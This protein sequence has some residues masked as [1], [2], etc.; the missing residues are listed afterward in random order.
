M[1]CFLS[2]RFWFVIVIII[3][4]IIKVIWFDKRQSMYADM[5]YIQNYLLHTAVIISIIM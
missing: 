5:C 3:I 2:Q 1:G 4:I